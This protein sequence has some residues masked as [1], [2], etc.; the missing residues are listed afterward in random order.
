MRQKGG[1]E[2]IYSFK[3]REIK[4]TAKKEIPWTLDGEYGGSH[5]EVE[6]RNIQQ[7]IDIISVCENSDNDS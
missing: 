7:A 4:F 3:A 5:I 1:E 2:M 6:V